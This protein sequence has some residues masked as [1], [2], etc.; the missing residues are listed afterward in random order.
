MRRCKYG[1]EGG[2]RGERKDGKR[3][4]GKEARKMGGEKERVC[5]K[6]GNREPW[7]ERKRGRWEEGKRG[8]GE[9]G[10]RRRGKE[11]RE[12]EG[13]RKE[14]G[15]ERIGRKELRGGKGGRK[16]RCRIWSKVKKRFMKPS[17]CISSGV[18]ILWR[19]KF[20][21]DQN[22]CLEIKSK[23][24]NRANWL[25][26]KDEPGIEIAMHREKGCWY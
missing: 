10:K 22:K 16:E 13:R 9:Q 6:E 19:N 25:K 1:S 21:K 3:G 24:C 18:I 12:G 14:R 5:V 26:G 23:D 7:E 15:K 11:E 2:K 8:R 20:E 4:R 17:L